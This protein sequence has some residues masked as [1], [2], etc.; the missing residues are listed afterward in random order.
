L[1]H[2]VP[3][4]V[5]LALLACGGA[6]PTNHSA[7]NAEGEPVSAADSSE[8]ETGTAA[9]S[10]EGD[11]NVFQISESDTA[12]DARGVNP[13]K[14]KPT[15]SEAALRLFVVDKE[16][17]P[18]KGIVIALTSP[19]GTKYYT[20]ETDAEGYAEALVPVGQTYDMTYLTL[21][22]R[23]VSAKVTVSDKPNQN[24]KLT[25]RYK[26]DDYLSDAV[27]RFVL[28][29]V[30]FETGKATLTPESFER[31]DSVVE[32]M[33]Y[34]KSVRIEISG[35]TD[36]VGNPRSN[37]VL[38]EKRAKACRDYVV[39]KGIKGDRIKTIG[40]GAER[41]IASNDTEEGRQENRRIEA[42][43]L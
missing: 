8:A 29:G 13:S 10:A 17:G 1:N 35:H 40:Y 5:A 30:Q 22:R 19:S 16:N 7:A 26:R 15:K 39:S 34:K 27:R 28:K 2:L 9:P 20:D 38:S 11:S 14:I 21:G 41:P 33:T 23:D 32:Y 43:E 31:L 24:L 37:K 3:S 6:K 12:A 36:N 18:I 42:T 25:L 4:I